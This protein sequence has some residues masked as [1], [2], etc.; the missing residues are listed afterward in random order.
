MSEQGNAPMNEDSISQEEQELCDDVRRRFRVSIT[1]EQ[2]GWQARSD[3]PLGAG[4]YG[5]V[6]IHCYRQGETDQDGNPCYY[7]LSGDSFDQ[8]TR[9]QALA[10]LGQSIELERSE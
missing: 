7:T 9:A 8:P 3:N 4:R 2:L 5:P 10:A 1:R 6:S